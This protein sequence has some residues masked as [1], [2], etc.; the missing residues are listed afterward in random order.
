VNK[1]KKKKKKTKELPALG[2][3]LSLAGDVIGVTLGVI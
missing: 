3:S 2:A 1:K